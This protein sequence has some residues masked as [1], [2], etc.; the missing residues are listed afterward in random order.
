MHNIYQRLNRLMYVITLVLFLIHP[1]NMVYYV[2]EGH[3]LF[4]PLSKL[5][6]YSKNEIALVSLLIFPAYLILR[7]I[8]TGRFTIKPA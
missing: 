7:W 3:S 6:P 2:Y 5:L 8:L 1:L 4:W